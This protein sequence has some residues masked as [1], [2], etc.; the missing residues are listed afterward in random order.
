MKKIKIREL[1]IPKII[2]DILEN[3][4]IDELYPPQEQ[5]VRN[6][7]LEGRNIV[8]AI[9]TAAGKTLAA[10][11]AI[12]KRLLEEGG[13]AIYLTPLK[14]LASEKYE[15]FKKYE[16]AGLKVA[17]ST[18]DYDNP[19]PQLKN[20]NIIVMTNEKADSILRNKPQWMSEVKV[21]VADEIH[22]INDN[23]RGPTLEVV[24]AKLLSTNSQLQVIGL[25]ATIMN[26]EE[27]AEWLNAR[28]VK[29]HWRPVPL[30]KGIYV[31]GRI[32]Y[33]DENIVE[34]TKEKIDPCQ[35]LT[36]QTLED[37]GQVLIFTN[38]RNDSRE[39]AFKLI[40]LT[41]K[42]LKTDDKKELLNVANEILSS[43]ESTRISEE[44]ATCIKNGIAFHHAGLSATHRNIVEKAF[45]ESK[46]KVICATP[47]LAAGVNLPARRVIVKSYYRYDSSTGYQMIPTFE[48]HQMA[49]RAG[50]P[51]YDEYG[52]AILIAKN[53]QEQEFLME[54]YVKAPP[55]KIWS[56][57][58]SESALRSHTLAIITT[59]FAKNEEEVM[60]FIR[61]TFYYKQYGEERQIRNV[62]RRIMKFLVE[63]EMIKVIDEK[64]YPT[65]LG[66]RVSQ[67]YIDP[68]SAIRII[69]GLKGKNSASELAYIH[70]ICMT[71]DMQRLHL[72]RKDRKI[73]MPK[74][75]ELEGKLLVNVKE[76]TDEFEQLTML[77]ALKTAMMLN[78]WIN[79]E[80][81]DVIIEKYDVGPGD[82]YSIALTAQWLMYSATEISKLMGFINH[83]QKLT[84]LT[85]RLEYGCKPELLELISLK[86]IG[87]VRARLLYRAGYKTIED[88]K[89][90]RIEDLR[91]I[92]LFGEETIRKIKE[93][94]EEERLH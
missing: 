1:S 26:A 11:L 43:E 47:T 69:N 21:V 55:E 16:Y 46:I 70:L 88:L 15:E 2:K 67:L 29:S 73:L 33:D 6:G 37:G 7:L 52:D 68:L 91:K 48:Y 44:L 78:E 32:I 61:R 54:N 62:L 9:P 74:L 77:Q 50:R 60:E 51:K 63:N 13:K 59:E 90:A 39:T 4:G 49:G 72:T 40:P 24:L 22:L 87:R 10:E 64:V 42:Y 82:I 53:L 23:D 76:F 58:A 89:K 28:L 84:E 85:S 19:E 45:K 56:R 94:L 34:V 83:L 71:P 30:R 36:R 75:L 25:S 12:T 38:T 8:I 20:Y 93:Q 31:N 3:N 14:A 79:E 41:S 35:A 27:I 17:I 86:G 92:P 65:K 57:L 80:K 5:A 66:I 18:G 81:E